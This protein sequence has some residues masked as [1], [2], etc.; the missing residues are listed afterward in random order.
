MSEENVE[1][2]RRALE[3]WNADDLDG[4]LSQLH[5]EVEWH[6]SIEQAVE[7]NESTYRGHQGARRAWEN[8]RGGAFGHLTGHIQEIR[9]LG[10][11][12]LGLGYFEVTGAATG[13]DFQQEVGLLLTFRDGKIASSRDYLSHAQ[14]LE[15][16]GLRE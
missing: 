6:G 7:G 1:T 16:A 9:D 8:Y 11:S 5:P 15:A 3:A 2:A 4:Y 10:E 12:V 14:A 13:I